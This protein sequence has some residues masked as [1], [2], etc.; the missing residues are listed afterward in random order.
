MAFVNEAGPLERLNSFI[1]PSATRTEDAGV[2]IIDPAH[3]AV[4]YDGDGNVVI[5]TNGESAI[6]IILSSSLD[7]IKQGRQVHFLLKYIGLI[8]AG[9][10]ISK[11]D[12]V[13]I[14]AT[15]QAVPADSGDFIFGRAFTGC[16][17]AGEVIQ[18]QINQMG[19]MA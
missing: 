16:A 8:S 2:D 18:V 14:N 5:A 9:D 13:T 6:G 3:K 7:P 15:G 1:D 4:M 10:E 19:Y 11:G 17:D 12:L